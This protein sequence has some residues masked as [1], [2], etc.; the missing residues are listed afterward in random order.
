MADWGLAEQLEAE[1]LDALR[2]ANWQRTENGRKGR[3]MPKP[4]P[5]PWVKA[6]EAGESRHFGAEPVSV[7]DFR[8][9]WEKGTA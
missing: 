9:F 3:K 7:E 1:M 8:S 2:V 5:R 6:G 4:T